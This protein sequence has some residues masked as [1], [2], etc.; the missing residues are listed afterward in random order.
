[1][2]VVT[3]ATGTLGS[4][5]VERLLEHAPATE[6]GV[7]VRDPAAAQDLA[8]RGV[9]VRHGDF[10]APES[11]ADAFAGAS[12]VLV[13]SAPLIGAEAVRANTAAIDAAVAAGAEHVVYTSHQAASSTSRFTPQPVHAAT[14]QHL[15]GTGVP[16]TALR[17]GF[18]ASTVPMLVTDA[19]E[20]G[21]LLAPADGPV[22]WTDHADLAAAAAAALLGDD[23]LT[24]ISA[25]LTADRT[26]DL[27]EV[28]AMLSELTG[29]QVV[30]RVVDDEAWVDA[31]VRAGVPEPRAR[32]ALTMHLASRAGEFDVTDPLLAE[33]LGRPTTSLRDVMAGWLAA[34]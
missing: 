27:A 19:L 7:S 15:A 31:Q 29:R 22:S 12:R 11:L 23:R 1:M 28:A 33:V 30:R 8:G 3:G 32:F 18:Y 14:E 2:I 34:R 6:V 13:V 26:L 16:F 20:S 5:V 24:G 9:R 10:S 4:L 25:P 21:E 17:N